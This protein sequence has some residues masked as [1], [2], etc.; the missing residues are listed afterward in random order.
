MNLLGVIVVLAFTTTIYAQQ[1][2][3]LT[4]ETHPLITWSLCTAP[5]TCTTQ[6]GS[7][8]LDADW[9]WLHNVGGYT[10]CFTGNTFDASLCPDPLTCA[11]NCALEGADYSGTYGITTSGNAL[12][13]K[14]PSTPTG[15]VPGSKVY[16]LASN[17]KYY[18]WKVLNREFAFDVDVS[19]LGCGYNGAFYLTSMDA[20]GG[21]SKYP[22]NK[23]GAK[24]GTGYCDSQCPRNL[25]FINGQVKWIIHVSYHKS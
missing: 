8:V 17:T 3:T 4:A 20:D 14:Q 12:T 19:R 23:A 24:Y 13:L 18:Q 11:A 5:G 15:G 10:N 21:M 9:R 7:V 2:G 25:H 6:V 22:T 1:V 16:F